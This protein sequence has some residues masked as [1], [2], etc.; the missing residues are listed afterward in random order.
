MT[1]TKQRKSEILADVEKKFDGAKSIV[2]SGYSGIT[3]KD[4]SKVR[5]ALREKKVACKIAKKTLIK[6]AAKKYGY[7]DIP[8]TV[9][10][11]PVAALFSY[12]DEI[13]G[14]KVIAEMSR[15]YEALKL[16]GGL[17]E[18]KVLSQEEVV[19]LSKLASREELLVKM[20]CS[21]NAPASGFANALASV[22][23]KLVYVLE[24]HRVKLA[25]S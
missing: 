1:I 11:G 10:D 12:G 20:L 6:I 15:K 16:F 13:S 7:N 4:F 14:A 8:D 21:L 19:A 23:R 17:M 5:R 25:Q 22:T 9:M 18:G 24:A 2:F 3:V